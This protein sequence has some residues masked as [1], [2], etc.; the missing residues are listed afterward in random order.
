MLGQY[1]NFPEIVHGIAHFTH[2]IS[3]AKLQNAIVYVFHRL[4]QEIHSL[5]DVAPFSKLKCEVSFEFGV[6]EGSAFNYLDGEELR[7]V[8]REIAKLAPSTLDF[9][10]VVRY[11]TIDGGR[12][13]PL[14]FDYHLLRLIF[15]RNSMELR[16]CHERGTQRIPLEDLIMFL[17]SR[18][19]KEVR[20]R[21]LRSL[22][23]KHLRAL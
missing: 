13:I 6:A 1:E 17:A 9:F 2:N 3:T 8:Q 11:H 7:R 23:L 20:R 10:F 4:N 18:L 12:R 19:G 15:R 14:K 22:N 5:N 16:I 21:G